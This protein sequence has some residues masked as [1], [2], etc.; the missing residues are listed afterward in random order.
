MDEQEEIYGSIAGSHS[1]QDSQPSAAF[2]VGSRSRRSFEIVNFR[3]GE[4]CDVPTRYDKWE[5]F[6]TYSSQGI[7]RDFFYFQLHHRYGTLTTTQLGSL[8]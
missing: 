6:F 5:V 1:S 2:S 4:I 8:S 7:H 3:L